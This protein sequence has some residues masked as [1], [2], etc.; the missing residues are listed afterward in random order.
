MYWRLRDLC[1]NSVRARLSVEASSA[2]LPM[3]QR[4]QLH[5]LLCACDELPDTPK[6]MSIDA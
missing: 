3:R 2:H 1:Q 5:T 6:W 4:K